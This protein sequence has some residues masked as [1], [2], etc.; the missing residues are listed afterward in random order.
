MVLNGI[1]SNLTVTERES[2][3]SFKH[4]AGEKN[5]SKRFEGNWDIWQ[6]VNVQKIEH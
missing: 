4:I 5:D 1:L 2:V 6:I 3:Y